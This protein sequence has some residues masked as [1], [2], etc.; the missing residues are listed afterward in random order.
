MKDYPIMI[1]IC[2]GRTTVA[3]GDKCSGTNHILPT[4]GAEDILE[5]YLLENLLKH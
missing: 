2:W 5:V 4:K 3:Y 1:F